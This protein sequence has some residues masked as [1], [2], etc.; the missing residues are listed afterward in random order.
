MATHVA[1]QSGRLQSQRARP[2]MHRVRERS[3]PKGSPRR[4]PFW[5]IVPRSPIHLKLLHLAPGPMEY[6]G[7]CLSDTEALEGALS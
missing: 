1:Q 5:R 6:T 7:D 3:S 4:E 2:K